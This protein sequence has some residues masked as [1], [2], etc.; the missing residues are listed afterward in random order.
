MEGESSGA[1]IVVAKTSLD[2][3]WRGVSVVARALRDAGFEVILLGMATPESIARAAVD[4]DAD[5]VG[6]NVGGRVVVAERIIETL[7]TEGYEGPVFA[8]G[9]IP[10]YAVK[11]LQESGVE[12][13][14]PGSSL[15]AIVEAARRLTG[16]GGA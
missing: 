8:G 4:E 3:H 1:R 13:F 7:R 15:D 5:L 10:P 16:S 2:G 11:T 6:L 14:P 9:T 12:C